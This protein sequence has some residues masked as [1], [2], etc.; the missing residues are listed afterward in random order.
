MSPFDE[1]SHES[2]I[3]ALSTSDF[4]VVLEAIGTA[5]QLTSLAVYH[6]SFV[7]AFG[8]DK[9]DNSERG[10]GE[11]VGGLLHRQDNSIPTIADTSGT[12]YNVILPLFRMTM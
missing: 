2:S 11:H 6:V 1:I 10:A 12:V 8:I 4:D 3:D 5:L 7:A 9:Y